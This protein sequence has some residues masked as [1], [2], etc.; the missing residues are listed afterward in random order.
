M[1]VHSN[2]ADLDLDAERP[3]K[4]ARGDED[5]TDFSMASLARGDIT[6]VS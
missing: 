4:R 5:G 6:Q 3:A 2:E 1:F